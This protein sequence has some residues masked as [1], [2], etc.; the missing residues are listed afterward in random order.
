MKP[1]NPL[2]LYLAMP[3]LAMPASA[4]VPVLNSL[5]SS[6]TVIFLDFDGHT[7]EGTTWNWNGPIYCGPSGLSTDQDLEVFNRVAEDYRP[8]A[9][10]ITT[11]STKFHTASITRRVRVVITVTNSWYGNSGGVAMIGSFAWGDD[12]PCFVFTAPHNFNTRNIAESASHE[13]GHTLGLYHQSVYDANC[14]KTAEYNTGVGTGE[15]SW[16]P[17]MGAGYYRNMTLWNNGP[18]NIGCTNYQT[19]L[20]IITQMNNV[21]YRADDHSATFADA[22]ASNIVNNAFRMEGIIERNTDHDLFRFQLP[23]TGAIRLNA[24][25]YNVGSNNAG[26]NLDMQV[27]LYN[28]NQSPVAVYNPGNFLGCIVDTTLLAGTY[29]LEVEG[30]GNI[31]APHYASLGAYAIQ[32]IRLEGIL[33][34]R[35]LE[36]RGLLAGDDHLLQWLIDADEQVVSQELQYSTDGVQYRSL[37]NPG[38]TTRAHR[39]RPTYGGTMLY[40][41]HVLFDNGKEYYSNIATLRPVKDLQKPRLVSNTVEQ[42]IVISSPGSY[43]YVVS[44][45]NGVM[46]LRGRVEKGT[47]TVNLPSLAS[48]MY[49]VRFSREGVQNTEK[50]VRK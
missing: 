15:I 33:P 18:N 17:I 50:F 22:T 49:I 39:Y 28:S 47:F 44:D 36:L 21:A 26:S 19:E 7:V 23:A 11:D 1:V 29:Y 42:S 2:L 4:Q 9:I 37:V 12:T 46:I 25:P 43:D 5:P 30:R 31:Y 20:E 38:E 16:A 27:T 48:G 13:A 6:S 45:L 10:N 3:L 41:L 40:R 8:F 32:G 24:V 34:L 14:V 35:R